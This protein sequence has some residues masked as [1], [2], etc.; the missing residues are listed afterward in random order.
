MNTEFTALWVVVGLC[1]GGLNVVGY[2]EAELEVLSHTFPTAKHVTL[3]L[4]KGPFHSARE[5]FFFGR[6][7]WEDHGIFQGTCGAGSPHHPANFA[8]PPVPSPPRARTK[9][10][11]DP[12]QCYVYMRSSL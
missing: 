7:G 3:Q 1:M 12:H 2:F 9:T 11:W 5:M 8:P 10:R 6:L 4:N